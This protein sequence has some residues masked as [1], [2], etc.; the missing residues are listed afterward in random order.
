V[1]LKVKSEKE[2]DDAEY[3]IG[4]PTYKLLKR[5]FCPQV[6]LL[7]DKDAF[8]PDHFFKNLPGF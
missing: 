4:T 8:F 5:V 6:I 2:K 1:L 7:C 3:L